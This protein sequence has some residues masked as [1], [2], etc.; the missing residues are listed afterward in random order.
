[1]RGMRVCGVILSGGVSKRFGGD[2]ALALLNGEP[3]IRHVAKSLHEAVEEVWLSVR[4]AER[5]EQLMKACEP[6]VKGYIVDE[7]SA[8]PLSGFLSAANRLEADVVVTSPADVPRIKAATFQKLVEK[9]LHHSASVASVVWGNGA[10]ETLVQVLSVDAVK[11]YLETVFM[12]RGGLHRP[13]DMLRCASKML[14]AA[15]FKLSS[16]PYEFSNINTYQ[17]LLEPKPRGSGGDRVRDDLLLTES[18]QH[19]RQAAAAA[20]EKRFKES[21]QEYVSEALV[22]LSYGVAHLAG[23][24]LADAAKMFETGR[25]PE[26]ALICSRMEAFI[27]RDMLS[28]M[29]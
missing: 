15:G 18:S 3:L 25:S 7:F 17:D 29:R 28:G 14:L 1:M 20:A 12:Y 19:F 27:R 10:V 16:D 2:K 13:S 23:H 11:N 8:G 21:A 4:D 5:G 9:F 26:A 24:A 22:L 6:F